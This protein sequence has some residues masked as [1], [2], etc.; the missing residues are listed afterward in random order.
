MSVSNAQDESSDAISGAAQCERLDSLREISLVQLSLF[1][2]PLE[3][4]GGVDLK[5]G[6]FPGLPLDLEDGF[7][8][9]DNLDHPD[10]VAGGQARV[11]SHA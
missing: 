6:E 11:G 3:Q 1:L 10:L 5:G 9:S 8:V 7:G 2:N 4:L